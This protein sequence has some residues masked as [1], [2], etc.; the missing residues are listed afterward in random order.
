[1]GNKL[2]AGCA[3]L[4]LSVSLSAC[5]SSGPSFADVEKDHSKADEACKGA[6]GDDKDTLKLFVPL[7]K[8]P[9]ATTYSVSGQWRD[10]STAYLECSVESTEGSEK[11]GT[12]IGFGPEVA[13]DN[14]A[15]SA[16]QGNLHAWV[17]VH[18]S[19]GYPSEA[20]GKLDEVTKNL[21]G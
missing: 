11:H 17:Y 8:N 1:M 2:M 15:L 19:T 18:P 9:D 6:F 13:D 21:A 14:P 5:G 12:E 16:Q 20:Q 3:A 10:D 4:V 7:A